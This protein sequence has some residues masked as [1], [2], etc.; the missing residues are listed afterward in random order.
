MFSFADALPVPHLSEWERGN[1]RKH[2]EE[3]IGNN[4][5]SLVLDSYNLQ[6]LS[7][8]CNMAKKNQCEYAEIFDKKIASML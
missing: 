4:N 8:W 5:V 7:S 6:F 2:G 3:D 1:L